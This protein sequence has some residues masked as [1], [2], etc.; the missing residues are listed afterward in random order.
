MH[1]TLRHIGVVALSLAVVAFTALEATA[2]TRLPADSLERIRRYTDWFLA[3][4]LDSVWAHV[5]A[6]GRGA[7]TRE[8]LAE[9]RAMMAQATGGTFELVE[10]RFVWRGG[11]RQYWR[12][13]RSP[14]APEDFVLRWVVGSDGELEGMGLN[15]A[16]GVPPVDSGGPVIRGGRGG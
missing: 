4:Q 16:S 14:A 7:F 10:E 5:N 3:G 1:Y 2:Q 11:A 6:R 8:L 9:R 15:L 12:T 13:M